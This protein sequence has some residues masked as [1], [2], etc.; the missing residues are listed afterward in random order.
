MPERN[1]RTLKIL[2][3]LGILGPV[4]WIAYPRINTYLENRQSQLLAVDAATGQVKWRASLPDATGDKF[5]ATPIALSR[6]RIL[7]TQFARGGVGGSECTWI[8]LDRTSGRTVWRQDF[9]ALGLGGCPAP[10]IAPVAQD[11][12]LYTFWRNSINDGERSEQGILAM[13]FATHKILW[14]VPISLRW[15]EDS[16][17][18]A[19]VLTDGKLIAGISDEYQ[20]EK[21]I[22]LKAFNPQT[23]DVMW[24]ASQSGSLDS[25]RQ[26]ISHSKSL[27]FLVDGLGLSSQWVSHSI[28]TGKPIS[29]YTNDAKP[30]PS[31]WISETLLKGDQLYALKVSG[32][33]PKV[34][35]HSLAKMKAT[36]GTFTLE[37]Q[38]PNLSTDD[39]CP[40]LSDLYA[41]K[42]VF[43]A[44]CKK[45]G[46]EEQVVALD[47]QT[48]KP[49]WRVQV[50]GSYSKIVADSAGERAFIASRDQIRAI[51]LSNGQVL[52]SLPKAYGSQPM[53]N[54]DTLYVIRDR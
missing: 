28:D 13:D 27:I 50:A 36:D 14:N 22:D 12:K 18:K 20:K 8:E 5:H 54:G 42:R 6:D 10:Y 7:V 1:G 26:L 51:D 23:G 37:N 33:S 38:S 49:K 30:K 11:G 45:K 4:L 19:L 17:E 15:R 41:A 2:L 21:G 48:Y 29:V 9:P 40:G 16:R 46:S 52:W 53:L 34:V 24:Q 3:L 44:L 39:V 47:D 35:S 32:Q 25:Y 43:L 31:Q